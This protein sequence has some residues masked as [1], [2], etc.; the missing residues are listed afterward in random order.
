MSISNSPGMITWCRL[1][2]VNLGLDEVLL[3]ELRTVVDDLLQIGGQ[4]LVLLTVVKLQL[5][6]SL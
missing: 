6:V 2:R 5:G 3:A 4:A 1:F